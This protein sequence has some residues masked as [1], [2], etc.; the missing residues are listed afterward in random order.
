MSAPEDDDT[1]VV[2][3]AQLI[4]APMEAVVQADYLA[5]VRSAEIIER[6]GFEHPVERAPA[7]QQPRDALGR[8][9]MVSFD[10]D[11]PGPDGE[12]RP[13]S[14]R[15]PKLSLIPLPL[16]HVQQASFDFGIRV[17]TAQQHAPPTGA[18]RLP[19]GEDDDPL[20][21][22]RYRWRAMLARSG[23]RQ[24]GTPDLAPHIDANMKVK[25]EM[26][27]SDLPGGITK[28][29][30]LMGEN[31]DVRPKA[32]PLAVTPPEV[33]LVLAAA[34]PVLVTLAVP[35][36]AGAPS[37]PVDL[38]LGMPPEQ[39]GALVVARRD[40][41]VI[42][43]DA[44][45]VRRAR[46]DAL[47]RLQVLVAVSEPTRLEGLTSLELEV[48][49]DTVE[50]PRVVLPLRLIR[51]VDVWLRHAELSPARRAVPDVITISGLDGAPRVGHPVRLVMSPSS[52][53][54]WVVRLS[55]QVVPADP[56]GVRE[57]RTDEAGQ[58][59]L[60]LEITELTPPGAYTL[61]A[62]TWLEGARYA[63]P[64]TLSVT[65]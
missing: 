61:E 16:L 40:G 3:L 10:I 55:G 60:S 28:L 51:P 26:R 24:E 64:I 34:E 39:A 63:Q 56:H 52:A 6:F 45:G 62:E 30:L 15:I 41:G 1:S 2:D 31:T 65:R 7:G 20:P 5:A 48:G 46:T 42:A 22:D 58:L 47:G 9:A 12:I 53:R 4:A 8:L 57:V 50:R 11:R 44:Q 49:A 59:R 19:R 14:V 43:P 21:P 17:V 36:P 32:P 54:Q 35:V 25:V 29:L 33:A 27:Q 38:L 18:L 23:D 37:H 13:L